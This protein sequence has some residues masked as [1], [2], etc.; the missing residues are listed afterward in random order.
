MVAPH[1]DDE[2]L[3]CSIALYRS[4]ATVVHVTNG[5]PPWTEGDERAELEAQRLAESVD[6]WAALSADV[7][8]VGLGFDDLGAWRVADQ[9]VAPLAAAI[10]ESGADEV[11]LPGYQAGHPDHDASYLAGMLARDRLDPAITWRVYGLYGYDDKRNVR[12]GWLHRRLYGPVTRTGGRRE[13]VAA[14][15][16]ALGRFTSQLEPDSM[17]DRWLQNPVGENLAPVPE[18][19]D[20]LPALPS[21][22]DEDMEFGQYGAGAEVV[23]EAFRAALARVSR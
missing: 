4:S 11:Y 3:G 18:R 5:A 14:K 12:F 7:N 2:V 6:A 22:F 15:T 19:W 23:A 21:F 17:L 8:R 1:P 20:R 16:E 13:L 9:I 10:E